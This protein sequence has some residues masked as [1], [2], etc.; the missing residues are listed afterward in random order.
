M[1]DTEIADM[2]EPVC[3]ELGSAALYHYQFV[4]VV[5]VMVPKP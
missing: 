5:A 1:S 3:Y 2:S 4:N